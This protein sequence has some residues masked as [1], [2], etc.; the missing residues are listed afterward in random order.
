MQGSSSRVWISNQAINLAETSAASICKAQDKAQK[1][2]TAFPV[3]I[4]MPPEAR[5]TEGI[6]LQSA[7]QH[8]D[9]DHQ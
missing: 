7:C 2:H 8:T 4:Y 3:G 5:Q 9:H 6:I 1:V